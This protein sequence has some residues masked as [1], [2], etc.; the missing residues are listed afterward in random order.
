MTNREKIIVVFAVLAVLY[1]G[2]EVFGSFRSPAAE[3]AAPVPDAA[4]N[5]DTFI[6]GIVAR[7]AKSRFS[8][9]EQYV[10][11]QPKGTWRDPFLTRA[12]YPAADEEIEL[13]NLPVYSGYLG[14][15]SRAVAVIGGGEYEVGDT[16]EEIDYQVLEIT[17]SHVVI[18]G[19]EKSSRTIPILSSEQD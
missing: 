8:P 13:K 19:A 11:E 9:A 7:L 1:G 14:M 3:T 4:E 6:S 2:Y 15:G 12:D 5:F 17:P 18:G 16:L 10:M